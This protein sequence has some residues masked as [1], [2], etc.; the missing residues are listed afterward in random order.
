MLS[1]I[2]YGIIIVYALMV[3][4]VGLFAAKKASGNVNEYFLSGRNLPWY[5]LGISGVAAFIDISG[6]M[7]QVSFF[8][9]LGVKGYWVAY[10]GALC[11]FLAFFMIYMAKWLNRSKVMT[12]AEWMGFRFGSGIQANAARLLTAIS[13]IFITIPIMAYLFIGTGKFL[14][15]YLPFSPNVCALIFFGI[16]MLYTV[17]S[18]LYGVVFTDLLQSLFILFIIVFMTIKALMIGTPEYFAKFTNPEW[19]TL[20]PSWEINMPPGYEN[21]HF[22][23]LLVIFW[24]ISNIFQGFSMPLDAWTSQRF[25]AAKNERESSLV[26]FQWLTLFSLRFPLMI[27]MGVLAVSVL[28]ELKDPE[29]ALPAVINHFVP[30]GLKGLLI[31]AM[32]AAGMSTLSAFINS[33]AAYFVNDIYHAFINPQANRKNLVRVSYIT[34]A[35][36]VLIGILIGWTLPNI[37]SIWAWIIMGLLTGLIPPG[38]LKWYWWRFNGM[39]FTLGVTA[40]LLGAAIQYIFFFNAPEYTSFMVVISLSTLG[41]II[42]TYLGKPTEMKTLINFYRITRPF[43]FWEPVRRLCDRSLVASVKKENKRDLLLLAPACIWQMTLYWMMCAFVV[44]KW[45]S[46]G[47][48]FAVV[49][50]ISVILYKYWY[51][52]LKDPLSHNPLLPKGAREA[53]K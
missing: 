48:S 22:F 7:L 39:G 26:A 51:L 1:S 47:I 11:L 28:T 36:I 50:V 23:A 40:G 33:S 43:G 2:D 3:L 21:M 25:Y 15:L 14:S 6:T 13:M 24:T 35:V 41:S 37:N 30:I 29:M 8:Y 12:N 16:V 38:I 52:N 10:R 27:G 5:L 53:R 34:S 49:T 19:L 20:T 46:F 44:K 32:I 9:L 18:G 31:S 17:A 45:V 4:V 42:G